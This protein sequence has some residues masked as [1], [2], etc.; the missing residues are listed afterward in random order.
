[1]VGFAAVLVLAYGL[2]L[3]GFPVGLPLF[4]AALAAVVAGGF[5]LGRRAGPFSETRR[6]PW[7][8]A[9]RVLVGAA[10]LYAVLAAVKALFFPVTA[11]DAHSYAGRALFMLHDRS[12]DVALYHWPE[13]PTAESNLSYPPLMSLAFAVPPAFGGWQ[14]KIVNVFLAL[15]WPLAIFEMLR[16]RLPRFAALAWALLLALTPEVFAHLSFDLLNLP[17]MAMTAVE[18]I[19]LAAFLETGDRRR[20]VIA[21]LGAAAA[22]GIRPDALAVHGALWLGV[23]LVDRRWMRRG[24]RRSDVLALGAVLAAPLLTWGTWALY[25][26]DRVGLSPAGP[27]GGGRPIGFGPV[28]EALG[29]FPFRLEVYGIVFFVFMVFVLLPVFRHEATPAHRYQTVATLL[30]AAVLVLLFSRIDAGYGGGPG[31]VLPFSFK[32]SLF[33]LVPTA[34]LAAALSP[35]GVRLA[36]RGS[37]WVHAAAAPPPASTTIPG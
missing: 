24:W 5:A 6:D 34:G 4:L 32:R 11:T 29:F 27:L 26:R 31:A 16:E 18:A 13:P 36:R 22:A 3:V 10:I 7:T 30:I 17:A 9:E 20:L 19:A 25:L 23:L 35:L 21:G 8:P 37:G 14:H 12:L 15:A 28:L 33:Y 2:A 1:L